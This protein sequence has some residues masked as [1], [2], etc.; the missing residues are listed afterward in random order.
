VVDFDAC[1]S[2]VEA[3]ASGKFLLKPVIRVIARLVSGVSG[4]VHPSLLGPMTGISL[5]QSGVAIKS[6][7]ADST[8]AFLLQPVAPGTYD[9]VITA[10][11]RATAVVTG[12]VVAADTVTAANNM[13]GAINPPASGSGTLLGAVLVIGAPS[14][15]ADVGVLQGLTGGPTIT[16]ADAP[17]NSVTGLYTYAMATAAPMVAA[18]VAP[19][20]ALTFVPDN[21][22]AGRM[23]LKATSNGV[24]QTSGL[25]TLTPGLSIT[26][27]FTFP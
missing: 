4:F 5:Q 11:G 8:G 7:M 21:A 14:I 6:T 17:V 12:V 19:P 25:L 23:T 16:L 3:G 27:N 1:K 9:L 13:V 26:T 18:A 20:G 15:D 22:A 2:V 10:P 24:S